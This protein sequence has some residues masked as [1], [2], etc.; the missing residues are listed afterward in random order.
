MTETTQTTQTRRGDINHIEFVSNDVNATTTFMNTLF[1]YEFQDMGNEAGPYHTFGKD[2]RGG[3][4][5]PVMENEPGPGTTAY[6]GV[7]NLDEAI[8]KAEENGAT[9]MVPKQPVP[10]MGWFAWI[11]APGGVVLALWQDDANAK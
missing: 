7:D 8:T 11:Q 2:G 9:L 6:V 1:G 4:V 5:R 3:A 10:T